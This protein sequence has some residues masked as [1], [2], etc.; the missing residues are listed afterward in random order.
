M[1]YRPALLLLLVL[2]PHFAYAVSDP[3]GEG[4]KELYT[5]KN[6]KRAIELFQEARQ[7]DPK[8]WAAVFMIGYAYRSALSDNKSALPYF[9]ESMKMEN[10]GDPQPPTELANC[11][12]DLGM[13]DEAIPVFERAKVAHAK[14]SGSA[15]DWLLE[16]MAYAYFRKGDLNSALAVA[17]NGSGM[18]EWLS[19]KTIT[20]RWRI[21]LR[22]G[23][24]KIGAAGDSVVRITIPL[25]RP[26]QTIE[27]FKTDLEQNG[28]TVKRVSGVGNRFIEIKRTA[29]A[30]P[31]TMTVDLRVKQTIMSLSPSSIQAV[32]K[33]NDPNY[34]YANDNGNG[35]YGLD[36]EEF[37]SKLRT[38]V[39]N[40]RSTAE[41]TKLVL[42][43]LRSHFKYDERIAG[44]N[45]V[46]MFN[47]GQGDCGYYSEIA[48]GMV[49]SQRVPVRFVYGLN[50][51]F[52]P[53]L[54]HAIL[55]I[56]DGKRWFPA[57]PQSGDMYGIIPPTYIPM[58]AYSSS[59][60]FRRG[61]DNVAHIDIMQFFWTGSGTETLSVKIVHEFPAIAKRAMDDKTPSV[62][63]PTVQS[64]SGGPV[65][66]K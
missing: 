26:Y 10:G 27:S 65:K 47:S 37:Q 61:S 15:P 23:L 63:V 34:E 1:R 43:Y 62:T 14:K 30:W 58:T 21:N 4:I 11:L 52:N 2:A 46:E 8:S 9:R 53:P 38:A 64:K 51:G 5:N 54:P 7:K 32:T 45:V 22:D 55:E 42:E 12:T 6:P 59:G 50:A 13:F 33:Q 56:Y 31:E 41:K 36:N 24:T 20:L 16:R 35:Y 3:Y 66:R 29:D 49:R 48:I 28:V 60:G 19:P 57:D 40:G 18:K 39:K 25:D 44:G 17:P